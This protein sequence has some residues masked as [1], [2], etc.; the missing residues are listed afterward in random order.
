MV[1]H[2]IIFDSCIRRVERTTHP[3]IRANPIR[4]DL[5][6][7]ALL[8]WLIDL[9]FPFLLILSWSHVGSHCHKSYLAFSFVLYIQVA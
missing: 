1:L 4:P 5:Q 7:Y 2:D 3:S 8:S 9:S 6:G